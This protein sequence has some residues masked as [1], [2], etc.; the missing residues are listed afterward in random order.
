ML[1]AELLLRWKDAFRKV[2]PVLLALDMVHSIHYVAGLYQDRLKVRVTI[3][4]AG[5]AGRTLGFQQI[6]RVL[7]RNGRKRILQRQVQKSL[8]PCTM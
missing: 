3:F 6:I 5:C 4:L 8:L 7:S 2:L 1:T